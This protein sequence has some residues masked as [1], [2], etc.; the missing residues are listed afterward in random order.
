M[1]RPPPVNNEIIFFNINDSH[2]NDHEFMHMECQNIQ[3]F[4]LKSGDSIN[5]HPNDNWKNTK[6]KY[7]YNEVKATWM[8]KY[9]MKVFYLTS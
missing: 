8:L 2:F 1:W 7:L 6:L 9:W 3:R 4:S 5:E